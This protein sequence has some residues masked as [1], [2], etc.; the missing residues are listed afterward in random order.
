MPWLDACRPST[1]IKITF[2]PSRETPTE[3]RGCR[4]FALS[5]A[6]RDGPSRRPSRT[7]IGCPLTASLM[8]DA[9]TASSSFSGALIHAVPARVT[10]KKPISVSSSPSGQRAPPPAVM[11]SACC[12]KPQNPP[13][14][15]AARWSRVAYSLTVLQRSP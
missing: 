10:A 15:A 1:T 14:V 5:N 7:S 12:M 11:P 4:R 9:A 13:F 6:S 2:L 8:R 3:V